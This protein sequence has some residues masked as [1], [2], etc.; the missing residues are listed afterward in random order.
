MKMKLMKNLKTF[1]K[2]NPN[3]IFF[4]IKNNTLKKLKAKNGVKKLWA[5]GVIAF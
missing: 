5:H 1:E 2:G 3:K 4:I